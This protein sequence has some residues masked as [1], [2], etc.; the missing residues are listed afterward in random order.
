MTDYT[1]RTGGPRMSLSQAM[2]RFK[3]ASRDLWNHCFRFEAA[4][5][6]EAYQAVER[7]EDVESHL[8]QKLIVDGFSLKEHRYDGIEPFYDIK[9]T[10]SSVASI[11][12]NREINSGYWDDPINL[13]HETDVLVFISFFDWKQLDFKDNAYVRARVVSHSNPAANGRDALIESW[14]VDFE[15]I[16]NQDNVVGF[17]KRS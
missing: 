7:F 12:L 11:M 5:T 4:D 2:F 9:V 15:Q 10:V 14:Q 8:F 17:V 16:P 3:T 1:L 6:Q 13:I